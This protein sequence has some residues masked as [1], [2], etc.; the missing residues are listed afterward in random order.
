MSFSKPIPEK[1]Y[2][3]VLDEDKVISGQKY[4]CMSFIS[5]EKILQ[6]KNLYMFESFVKTWDYTKSVELYNN[7]ISFISY[8]YKL[9]SSEI[10]D[11]L[12]EFI[13]KEQNK[14]TS[15]N[16]LGDYKNFIEHNEERIENQFNIDNKFQTSVRGI[17]IRGSYNTQEEAEMRA[18]MLRE[19]DNSHDVYVGQVGMW[20]PFDPDAYKTGKIDYLESELNDLMHAKIKNEEEAKYEFDKRI[21]ETKEKAIK[22][23]EQLAKESGNTLTQML[24]EDG[25]L[26]NLSKVD[27]DAIPDSNVVLEPKQNP[28]YN[29]VNDLMKHKNTN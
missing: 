22:E 28:S 20:M 29:I 11:D 14:L 9:S 23:N 6:D 2:V 17:K 5:P 27:Y 8:K 25:E 3:D 1:K 24:N 12:K 19:N 26:V 18:K 16:I 7:F 13:E 15:E 21:K 4:C 10:Q